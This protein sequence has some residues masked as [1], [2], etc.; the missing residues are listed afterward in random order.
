[1]FQLD[2]L[3]ERFDA[4]VVGAGAAG[5]LAAKLLCEGGAR[6]LILDAGLPPSIVRT[7]FRTITQS[8]VRGWA[9]PRLLRLV[10][11][12]ILY[13]GRKALK[14]V[15]KFRQP[16]QT[17]CYAWER[18]P[19]A[20]VDDIDCPYTTPKDKPFIWIRAW[21][22]GGK[23]IVPGHGRQYYRLSRED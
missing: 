10:P 3:I 22:M 7:P 15:G 12:S 6:V 13:K 2:A 16:V 8:V 21:T 14:I 9:D 4:I 11:P 18:L 5:G 23:M 20:F 1:M 19:E 17:N